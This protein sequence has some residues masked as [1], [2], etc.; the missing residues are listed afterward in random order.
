M[1]YRGLAVFGSK[2]NCELQA[3]TVPCPQSAD[4][5]NRGTYARAP[6]EETL[7]TSHFAGITPDSPAN[8][9]RCGMK[10]ELYIGLVA[11]IATHS[12]L[13]LSQPTPRPENSAPKHVQTEG[14]AADGR[15]AL[16]PAADLTTQETTAAQPGAPIASTNDV[17]I[18]G[19]AAV[20][21][22]PAAEAPFTLPT[23][24]REA[25]VPSGQAQGVP[26][27]AEPSLSF[28][29]H[30][31]LDAV[32]ATGRMQHLQFGFWALSPNDTNGGY[33]AES[34]LYARWSRLGLEW[35]AG[36]LVG[37]EAKVSAKL[38]IDFQNGGLE[39]RA[40]PRMRHAYGQVQMR[41]LT[42]IGGQT[43]DLFAP[44]VAGGMEQAIFWYGGNLGD[45]RPQLRVTYAPTFGPATVVIA[46]AAVQSGAVDMAD[47]DN[48]GVMDGT[49]WARPA[50]QGLVELQFKM[51]TLG[52]NPIRVG[53]S[54]HYGGKT[55]AIGG[56]EQTFKVVAVAGHLE[57]PV[58]IVT[59]RGEL[60]TGENLS[61]LRGG[62]G[63]GL[64]LTDSDGDGALEEGTEIGASGGWVH[65]N[66][67]PISWYSVTL[68]FGRDKPE[69]IPVGGRARNDTLNFAN[70]FTPW[71]PVKLGL[72]YDHYWTEYSGNRDASVSRFSAHSMV[73]F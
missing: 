1:R 10:R 66:V 46:A 55:L 50:G 44:L 67:V 57:L 41:A 17:V 6:D 63:Q 53:T 59:L 22:A 9:I 52:D 51:D 49:A 61:D 18:N 36:D 5:A 43:W 56:S 14:A 4:E 37:A 28:Y 23:D 27:Q 72:V 65:L 45:R 42:I 69:S 47:L 2:P 33:E 31:R 15:V 21:T 30:G 54:G 20:K 34:T 68:G 70:I 60:W 38:E 71:K 62:I 48:D 8:R 40:T 29:G 64:T 25:T 58:S 32:Y 26:P 35:N 12:G 7:S 73:S 13:A 16:P 39:S 3:P 19:D 24:A 11:A